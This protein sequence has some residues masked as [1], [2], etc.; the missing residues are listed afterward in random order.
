MHITHGE[1]FYFR[2]LLCKLLK[3]ILNLFKGI[4]AQ[5]SYMWKKY[6]EDNEIHFRWINKLWDKIEFCFKLFYTQTID[7]K[8]NKKKPLIN[9]L[10]CVFCI[11]FSLL[12]ITEKSNHSKTLLVKNFTDITRMMILIVI[13]NI[14]LIDMNIQCGRKLNWWFGHLCIRYESNIRNCL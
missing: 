3:R 1:L 4:V 12:Q 13:L 14:L 6:R 2:H 8:I 9:L 11:V 10:N 7:F 5:C